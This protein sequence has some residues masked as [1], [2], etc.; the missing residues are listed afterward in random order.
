MM[1]GPEAD[2][3]PQLLPQTATSE[4]RVVGRRHLLPLLWLSGVQS[5]VPGPAAAMLSEN[6]LGTQNLQT[7]AEA[8]E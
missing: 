5:V 2:P 3:I 1:H 6:L 7:E 8:R 4:S